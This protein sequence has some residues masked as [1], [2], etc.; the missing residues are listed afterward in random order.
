M[1]FLHNLLRKFKQW[2]PQAVSINLMQLQSLINL[3]KSKK[4]DFF[5][6]N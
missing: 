4:K 3:G 6:L 2:V 1:Y 5:V